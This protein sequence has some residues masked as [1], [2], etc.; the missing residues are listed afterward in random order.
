MLNAA[1]ASDQVELNLTFGGPAQG[2]ETVALDGL[3]SDDCGHDGDADAFYRHD[4]S[5][6]QKIQAARGQSSCQRRLD[7][8]TRSWAMVW[9]LRLH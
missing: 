7:R 6:V 9:A 8:R 5:Q 4:F 1:L 3:R 2:D